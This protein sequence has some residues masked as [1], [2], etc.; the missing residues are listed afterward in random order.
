MASI[1]YCNNKWQARVSCTGLAPE[2]ISF[3]TKQ[4]AAHW[5]SGI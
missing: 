4:D 5:Y 2:I 1:R 3:Q